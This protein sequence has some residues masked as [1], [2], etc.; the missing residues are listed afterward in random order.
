MEPKRPWL[1]L[2]EGLPPSGRIIATSSS[3][4]LIGDFVENYA[5]E[6]MGQA[7][8]ERDVQDSIHRVFH[9]VDAVSLR[10]WWETR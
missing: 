9:R 4:R 3:E 6:A 1:A 7:E 10:R 2:F 5:S 8:S